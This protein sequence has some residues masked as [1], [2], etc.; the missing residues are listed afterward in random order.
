MLGACRR[1]GQLGCMPMHAR[2]RTLCTASPPST[3]L[4]PYA[5]PLTSLPLYGSHVFTSKPAASLHLPR[6]L[7]LPPP[8]EG[9]CRV[10]P[11][12]MPSAAGVAVSVRNMGVQYRCVVIVY[13]VWMYS[14]QRY[15]ASASARCTIGA[16]LLLATD[17]GPD[18]HT[19]MFT[20]CTTWYSHPDVHTLV[21]TPCIPSG[22][23]PLHL[24]VQGAVSG[25]ESPAPQLLGGRPVCCR[26]AVSDAPQLPTLLTD[27]RPPHPSPSTNSQPTRGPASAVP[28]F[29]I[30]AP[31][32]LCVRTQWHAPSAASSP[33][34]P[35]TT[36]CECCPPPPPN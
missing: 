16:A 34:E 7:L 1:R 24:Q 8:L 10:V 27:A 20:P 29:Q 9:M 14:V 30:K 3:A 5:T 15:N 33:A 19:L 12:V 18:I 6:P 22:S 2:L 36:P 17:A 31:P 28:P 25:G 35:C 13:E 11:P 32:P 21:F 23:R 26:P 4:Q